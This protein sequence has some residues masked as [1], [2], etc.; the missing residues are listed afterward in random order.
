MP[1]S[2]FGKLLEGLSIATVRPL[3]RRVEFLPPARGLRRR[4]DQLLAVGTNIKRRIGIDF[5]E[6]QD[7]TVNHQRETVSVRSFLTMPLRTY[8]VSPWPVKVGLIV[9]RVQRLPTLA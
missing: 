1:E 6:I 8:N 4:D 9:P 5:E 3:L 7:G 2:L